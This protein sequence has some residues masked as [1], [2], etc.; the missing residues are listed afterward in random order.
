MC[1]A[2]SIQNTRPLPMNG[3]FAE[4]G[5]ETQ[6]ASAFMSRLHVQPSRF[7]CVITASVECRVGLRGIELPFAEGL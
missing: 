5:P 2:L 3:H 4:R 6:A 1:G 7:A